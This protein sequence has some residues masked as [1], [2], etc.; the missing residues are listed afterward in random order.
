MLLLGAESKKIQVIVFDLDGVVVFPSWGFANYL[1]HEHAITRAHTRDFFAGPFS[2]CLKGQLDVK[3]LLPPFLLDWGW[4]G[5]VDDFM[6]KWLETEDSA[7][8]RLV[9]L[10]QDLRKAGWNC[11]LGTNQ[12]KYRTD[13]IR[14]AMGF[15]KLFDR[16]FFSCELGSMKPERSYFDAVCD[17]LECQANSILFFD[18]EEHYVKAAKEAGWNAQLYT[19]FENLSDNDAKFYFSAP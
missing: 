7:D 8:I 11:A 15:E 14:H 5:T 18:N 12:E 1:E 4:T 19:S 16:L 13:Y 17:A 9:Q 10:I 3:E 2:Q 6:D